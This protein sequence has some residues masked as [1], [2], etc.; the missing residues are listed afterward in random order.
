MDYSTMEL[1][2]G[3]SNATALQLMK[4]ALQGCLEAT[5]AGWEIE[6]NVLQDTVHGLARSHE[7]GVWVIW[8]SEIRHLKRTLLAEQLDYVHPGSRAY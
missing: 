6:W 2:V 1:H 4:G 5:W 7:V 8:G 3:F